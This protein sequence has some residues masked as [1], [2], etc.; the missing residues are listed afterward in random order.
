MGRH[1]CLMVLTY[2][3]SIECCF[4]FFSI[5]GDFIFL[6]GHFFTSLKKHPLLTKQKLNIRPAVKKQALT[7]VG[8][9]EL[10]NCFSGKCNCHG[11]FG[12]KY[13]G[14]SSGGAI[15]RRPDS[16]SYGQFSSVN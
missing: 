10:V 3:H 4:F 9:S 7:P 16:G 12:T 15:N 13:L 8:N 5:Y 6:H 2:F 14:K 1:N 11:L